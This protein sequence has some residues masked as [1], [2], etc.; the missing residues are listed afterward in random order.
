MSLDISPV[1]TH[2]DYGCPALEEA[3]ETILAQPGI[4]GI[5]QPYVATKDTCLALTRP[6]LFAER[7]DAP[8][9]DGITMIEAHELPDGPDRDRVAAALLR[10][11][12]MS[13]FEDWLHRLGPGK[14]SPRDTSLVI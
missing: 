14:S 1:L 9:A 11:G 8:S 5:A 2:F 10:I 6:M 4:L 7:D 12:T 3:L 13:H